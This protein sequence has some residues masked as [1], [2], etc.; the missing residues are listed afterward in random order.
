TGPPTVSI[1]PGAVGTVVVKP[2]TLTVAPPA[3]PIKGGA[4]APGTKVGGLAPGTKV[5]GLIPQPG[6]KVTPLAPQVTKLD[7]R[8]TTPIRTIEPVRAPIT[9]GQGFNDGG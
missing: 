7:P 6:T 4:L 9:V 3:V 1:K 5:G 2:P 8:I